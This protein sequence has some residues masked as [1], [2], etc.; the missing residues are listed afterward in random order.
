MERNK[1]SVYDK[2][3]FY[4]GAYSSAVTVIVLAVVVFVNLLVTRLDLKL[5]ISASGLYTLSA[6][7]REFVRG[8][9]DDISIYYL[10]TEGGEDPMV[11]DMVD[12]FASASS[13]ITVELK[14]PQLYPNFVYQY[15]EA[16]TRVYVD[17]LIVENHT[18]GRSRFISA[19]EMI[20]YSYDQN[21]NRQLS[22]Y[23]VEGQITS[24]LQYVTTEDLPKI[25]AT[26][27]HG[28]EAFGSYVTEYLSKQNIEFESLETLTME[29]VPEDC[30]ILIVNGAANDFTEAEAEKIREY[31][32]GGGN[33]VVYYNYTEKKLTNLDSL[34]EYYGV[35]TAEGI[36]LETQ[37][38][39]MMS[40][41][42]YFVLPELLEHDVTE[43]SRSNSRY[44]VSYMPVGLT[45][46]GDIRGSVTRTGLLVSS[47][48]SFSKVDLQEGT[49]SKGEEDLD[50]PFY[51]GV[52]ATENYEDVTTNLVVYSGSAM[53]NDTFAG[54][55]A[56]GNAGLFTDTL[57][58]M[59][60][61]EDSP[62]SIPKK[63]FAQKYLM[64]TASQANRLAG[65]T[66]FLIPG[67]F[68]AAGL[69][70]WLK[71]RKK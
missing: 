46:S 20:L 55:T 3:R 18:N 13:H 67:A 12:K 35:S 17:S 54:N 50:G 52:A 27:G 70:V 26:A 36:V 47:E 29:T 31:L 45:I 37:A 58:W 65:V 44:V 48:D 2:R 59:I 62:I 11:R 24:A 1:K 56:L 28:E 39:R 15:V 14:D 23:D 63:E 71:R 43:S 64:L 30:Q 53:I 21:Y 34:M 51:L 60:E 6:E 9:E 10:A 49:F 5:D 61:R 33:L 16:D 7:T 69:V 66:I 32:A 40:N 25:Y 41:M 57:N 4:N 22:G 42:P 8:L 38:G 19:S 68:L